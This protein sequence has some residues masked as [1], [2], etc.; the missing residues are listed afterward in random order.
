MTDTPNR[1]LIAGIS[2]GMLLLAAA[3]M[4]AT[5]SPAVAPTPKVDAGPIVRVPAPAVDPKEPGATATA[6]IAGGCFWGVQGV[7]QHVDGVKS[8][9]SGYA[10][11]Q[12]RTANYEAVGSGSTGHAE[13]VK[14]TYDPAKVSY[15]TLLRIF[16]AVVADPTTLNRQGP[17]RGSQYRTAIFPTTPQQKAVAEAYIAQLRAAKAW[18]APIVTR[19][20]RNR[21]FYAAEKYHQDFLIRKPDY[22]YIVYNDLP[23]VEALRVAFPNHFEKR[24]VTVYP[25]G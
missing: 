22:P 24:P 9:V 1:P 4:I 12:A 14:I 19:V 6:V 18:K 11:G 13:A 23:K 7:Y 3:G 16:F 5:R 20:E 17:D 25:I 21:G 2:A 15:G 8:A 10:G